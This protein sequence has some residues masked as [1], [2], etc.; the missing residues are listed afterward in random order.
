MVRVEDETHT[1][2]GNTDWWRRVEEEAYA[3]LTDAAHDLSDEKARILQYVALLC[4]VIATTAG[5]VRMISR[6]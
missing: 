5:G 6:R 3:T 2:M 1:L 4:G